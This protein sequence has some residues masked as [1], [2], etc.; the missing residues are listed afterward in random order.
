MTKKLLISEEEKDRILNLH[1]IAI[2][3]STQKGI[4]DE[5]FSQTVYNAQKKLKPKYGH[6]LGNSGK[7]KDGV[8][9]LFGQ[10]TRKAILQY[11]K[12]NRLTST[13]KLDSETI[14]KMGIKSL[15]PKPEEKEKET[16][17]DSE[18]CKIHSKAQK[19][20]AKICSKISSVGEKPIGN[21][22]DEGCAQ[23][24]HLMTDDWIGNAWFSFEESAGSEKY[25]MFTNGSI[26]WSKIQDSKFVNTNSCACFVKEGQGLDK[27]C[28]G[29]Q[30][31][32]NTIS[33]FYPSKSGVDISS[34]E[35]GDIV[36]M[37][38]GESSN[39]GKAFCEAAIENGDLDDEGNYD[40]LNFTFNTHVGYVGAIK[41]GV[42]IIFHS[43]H[44]QRLATPATKLLNK[45]GSA[46]IT[47]VKSGKATWYDP[48]TWFE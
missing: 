24:V 35:V 19:N 36:G 43:V 38:Y 2:L 40:D 15:S 1:K 25:N 12:D 21:G 13:G 39:K 42:P 37:Y 29:G 4:L 44:G 18:S 5:A 28:P 14:N 6:L 34:L 17:T 47:W 31:I 46:M 20:D 3:E 48:T 8:D 11:Q 22:G 30:K 45:S 33:S 7:N 10:N 16:K 32:S 26:N 27:I 9:G 41:N 23:Y